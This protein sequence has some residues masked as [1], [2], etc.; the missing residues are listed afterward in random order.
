MPHEV[1]GYARD[2]V[3]GLFL[4]AEITAAVNS[5]SKTYANTNKSK[6]DDRRQRMKGKIPKRPV[7]R[8]K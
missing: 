3:A 7:P 5:K 2:D 4:S 1:L 8:K 6:Q